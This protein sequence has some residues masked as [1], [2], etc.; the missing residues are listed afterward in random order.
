VSLPALS[1]VTSEG[2]RLSL[3]VSFKNDRF[4]KRREKLKL[5][6]CHAEIVRT[7]VSGTLK[8]YRIW[9]PPAFDINVCLD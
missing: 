7:R 3:T 5:A 6:F 2:E 9:P 4:F 1:F 8:Y